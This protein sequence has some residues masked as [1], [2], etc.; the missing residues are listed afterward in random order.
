MLLTDADTFVTA[1][2]LEAQDP[3]V[4]D[5]LDTVNSYNQ[6]SVPITAQAAI[7]TALNFI[8]NELQARFVTYGDNYSAIRPGIALQSAI[9]TWGTRTG[10]RLPYIRLNQ[11]VVTSRY[12]NS[13]SPIQDW[14]TSYALVKL[15]DRLAGSINVTD[16]ANRDLFL[17]KRNKYRHILEEEL[18]PVLMRVGV[19]TVRLPLDC[20]GAMKIP[21]SGTWGVNN[22]TAVSKTGT[23]GGT[24]D[25]AITYVDQSQSN[26]Y[27]GP[28]QVNN[29]ESHPSAV[30]S[31]LVIAPNQ[32]LSV[33]ITS[34]NPPNGQ[35]PEPMRYANYS[36]MTAQATGWN[37]YI[38]LTGGTLFLQNPI[39]PYPITTQVVTLLTDPVVDAGYP[40]GFGQRGDE[41][42]P[43]RNL[44]FRM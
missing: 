9:V 23:S 42:T 33:S 2:D 32:A 18:F 35:I 38:G 30:I 28:G 7:D 1:D 36:G 40:M 10:S 8:G 37:L 43:I 17:Q 29:Y 31:G 3:S 16:S 39:A 21:Y 4:N 13:T 12:A 27:R 14:V 34:L 6:D 26:R 5:T 19:Q 11:V 44:A 22:V 41:D 25:I 24:F 15:Y 20:P